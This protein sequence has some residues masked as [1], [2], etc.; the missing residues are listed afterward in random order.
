MARYVWVS[1]TF[2]RVFHNQQS[3]HR[4]KGDLRQ[5]TRHFENHWIKLQL[6]SYS[7]MTT[8]DNSIHFLRSNDA[9]WALMNLKTRSSR[10]RSCRTFSSILPY[11]KIH[12]ISLGYMDYLVFLDKLCFEMSLVRINLWEWKMTRA[13]LEP[14][15]TDHPQI[16]IVF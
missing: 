6:V 5:E 11:W 8:N 1:Q 16:S 12:K 4:W 14:R 9:S 2:A 7:S 10:T 3:N 13:G 15:T